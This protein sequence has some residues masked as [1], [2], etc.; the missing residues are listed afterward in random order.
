LT[1]TDKDN[2]IPSLPGSTVA[3]ASTRATALSSGIDGGTGSDTI[4]NASN[5]DASATADA[6]S[7]GIAAT[8]S[9]NLEGLSDGASVTDSS[10]T[11]IAV[12]KGINGG[13]GGDTITNTGAITS[14]AT[15]SDN[16]TSV[17]VTVA[18][19]KVGV[20]AGVTLADAV[21]QATSYSYGIDGENAGG[22][23]SQ[24]V[25]SQSD[26]ITNEGQIGSTA[27]SIADA[28]AVGVSVS[29]S[30]EGIAV[31][32]ALTEAE[33]ASEAYATGI[34]SGV[35]ED[36]IDNKGSGG[37]SATS[38]AES[39][40]SSISVAVRRL[41]RCAMGASWRR[42]QYGGYGR[43][44]WHRLRLLMTPYEQR[45][46][47]HH[48]NGGCFITGHCRNR[49]SGDKRIQP[50]C[51]VFKYRDQSG[52]RSDRDRRRGRRR[53]DRECLSFDV[54]VRDHDNEFHNH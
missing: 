38:T 5:V 46:D 44:R 42:C 4:A 16:S 17:S 21:T 39:S 1:L 19:S 12:T 29:A 34:R 32:V 52:G 49:V 14:A 41:E 45:S 54:I 15:S 47:N 50:R 37:I 10:S 6:N 24:S 40:S 2:F 31:S 25:A 35:G 20:A 18:G 28:N 26:V 33:A 53:Y 27:H 23:E 8:I 43:G 13:T 48:V 51:G 22:D 11:S 7:L 9:G 3:D 30:L 36:T